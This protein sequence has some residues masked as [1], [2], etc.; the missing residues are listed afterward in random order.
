MQNGTPPF[1]P[2][3]RVLIHTLELKLWHFEVFLI[4]LYRE[5]IQLQRLR[6]R[7]HINV[8]TITRFAQNCTMD[9]C[10]V[11]PC[12][13]E[14]ICKKRNAEWNGMWNGIWNGLWN[15]LGLP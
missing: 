15:T 11:I 4:C 10:S 6:P 1:R 8:T 2:V 13:I 7:V 9:A 12:T 5:A 14:V 3:F